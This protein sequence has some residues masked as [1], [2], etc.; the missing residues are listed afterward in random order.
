MLCLSPITISKKS[1]SGQPYRVTV[2]CSRCVACLSRQRKAW[3][4]RIL[5]EL[6]VS[7]S[8]YFV[9]LTYNDENVKDVNKR[10][11]QLFL[12]KLRKQQKEKIR[13]YIV[14]EYGEKTNRPHY[15][16]IFFNLELSK[17][18]IENIWNQGLIHIGNVSSASINYVTKY[19]LKKS[20]VK[21]EKCFSL[22]SIGIGKNYLNDNYSY[23][24]N[25][26]RFYTVLEGGEKINLP[27]YYKEKIFSLKDK[28][29]HAELNLKRFN[30][31]QNEYE[32]KLLKNGESLG[33]VEIAQKEHYKNSINLSKNEKL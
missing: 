29:E 32:A 18:V 14:A 20:G 21:K 23:H 25:Q 28:R 31:L 22:C 1:G 27:R 33:N 13:Y 15:H 9:T 30:E 26:K 4:F 7:S 3:S 8:A 12:K 17:N 5:Q 19:M 2:P 16:G 11:I 6:K 24:K 10:D